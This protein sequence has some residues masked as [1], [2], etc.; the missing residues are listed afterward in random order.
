MAID[1]LMGKRKVERIEKMH[2]P[3]ALGP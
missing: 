3:F 2:Q 1:I